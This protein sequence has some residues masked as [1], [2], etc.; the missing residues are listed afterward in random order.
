MAF[1]SRRWF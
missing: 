1:S